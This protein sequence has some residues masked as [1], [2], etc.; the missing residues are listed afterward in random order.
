MGDTTASR[1]DV[2]RL[3]G[4]AAFGATK[5][6]LDTHRGTPYEVVVDHLL[7]IPDPATRAPAADDALRLTYENGGNLQAA[8]LW[9][10]DRMRTTAYPLEERMTLFWHDHWATAAGG[11][12]GVPAVVRQ[13][14]TIRLN[15]LGNFRTMCHAMTLDGAML[16]WLDGQR[17]IASSPNENYA[18]EF[19]ELFTL[20]VFP[21]VY[22]ETDIREAARAFTG[23]VVDPVSRNGRFEVSRHDTG[24]KRIL[25]QPVGN[26]GANEVNRVIDIALAQP[27]ASRFVAYKLVQNFAYVPSSQNLLVDKD[28]LVEVVAAALRANDWALRPAVRAM[29]LSDHFRYADAAQGRQVVRQPAEIT[30]HLTKVLGVSANQAAWRATNAAGQSVFAPPNVGGW[31]VGT[32]WLSPSTVTARYE[33]AFRVSALHASQR[34]GN[35][36]RPYLLPPS[37]DIKTG[38][39]QWAALMGLAALSPT[40]LQAA[41]TYRNARN[42]ANAPEHELQTGIL[43]ILATSPDWQVM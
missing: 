39:A 20:G 27:I 2:A 3:F 9:W 37:S 15:A 5:A 6:D 1:A 10:L 33:I 35:G 36:L 21:Q 13:N 30:V 41:K 14:Q 17:N 34:G 18:R 26:K 16:S 12:L 25:G 11:A 24:T 7:D 4:R 43:L 40:T 28:P 8:A 22:T 19:F 42:Q 32:G 23:W 29:L 38:G 31:P